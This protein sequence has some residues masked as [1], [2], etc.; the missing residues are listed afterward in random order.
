MEVLVEEIRQGARDILG[1]A[2]D[3]D[4]VDFDEGW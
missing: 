1:E 2:V 4:T 3:L